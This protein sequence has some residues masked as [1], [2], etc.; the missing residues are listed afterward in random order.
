MLAVKCKKLNMYLKLT[1]RVRPCLE[2]KD[3]F[4]EKGRKKKNKKFNF[5]E[6]R[7]K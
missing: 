7:G 1:F 2:V 6:G 5:I 4:Q 3:D